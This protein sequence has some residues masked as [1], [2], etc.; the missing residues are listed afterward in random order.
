MYRI[1]VKDANTTTT[2]TTTNRPF[3]IYSDQD[4]GDDE[5]IEEEGTSYMDYVLDEALSQKPSNE[6]DSDESEEPSYIDYVL[7]NVGLTSSNIDENSDILENEGSGQWYENSMIDFEGSGSDS[8][9]DSSIDHIE[10]IV[11][12][13]TDENSDS[14]GDI[15]IIDDHFDVPENI[16][17]YEDLSMD[18]NLKLQD[19]E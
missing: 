10:N 14:F 3:P 1:F 12:L 4:F 13:D 8:S 18:E 19:N 11:L 7:E 9:E 2:S 5:D 17:K 15:E 6:L 16:S